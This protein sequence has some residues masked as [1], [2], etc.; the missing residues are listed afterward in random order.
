MWTLEYLDIIFKTSRNSCPH[1][2]YIECRFTPILK[3]SS[4][5]NEC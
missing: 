4:P 2:L 5:F 3:E 1:W